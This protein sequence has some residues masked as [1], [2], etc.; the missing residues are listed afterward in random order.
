[1]IGVFGVEKS[2]IESPPEGLDG[3]EEIVIGQYDR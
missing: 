1:V 3:D 2:S